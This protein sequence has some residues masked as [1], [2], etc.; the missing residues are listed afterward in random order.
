MAESTRMPIGGR[1]LLTLFLSVFFGFGVVFIVIITRGLVDVAR[2]RDWNETPC[3]I[4]ASE[5]G[6]REEAEGD[7]PAYAFR[8]AYRYTHDGQTHTSKAWRL[9][10]KG[11]DQFRDAQRLVEHY[12]VGAETTCYVNPSEPSAAVLEHG[13]LWL[14]L[15]LLLPLVF[16]CVGAGGIYL[17]WRPSK[18]EENKE[19]EKEKAISSKPGRATGARVGSIV[20][21]AFFL[22]GAAFLVFWF[23]PAAL[24]VLDAEGWDET[25]CTVL[26]SRV[27]AH[28]G[29]DS[30]TYSVDILYAYTVDGKEYK[31]SGYNFLGGSSSRHRAKAEIVKRHKPG[32][33]TV[34]FVNPDDPWDAVLVRGFTAGFLFGLIP[35][36]FAAI[37]GIG[38]AFT[39]RRSRRQ[40]AEPPQ[41]KWVPKQLLQAAAAGEPLP[42]GPVVLKPEASPRAKFVALV[43]FMLIWNSIISVFLWDVVSGWRKGSPDWFETFFI[44]PF[45]LVGLGLIAGVVYC[46]LGLFSPRPQLTVSAPVAPLGGSLELEWVTLGR[47]GSVRKLTI[48]L[49]GREEAKYTRGTDTVTDEHVFARVPVVE[50]EDRDTILAGQASLVVP[51]DTMHSFEAAHNKI[52][53]SIHVHADVRRWP[54]SKEDYPIVVLPV[55]AAEEETT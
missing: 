10:D 11:F 48:A 9:E 4:I 17:L 6:L 46:F 30:T 21:G 2:T 13:S 29:D 24:R 54:D 42:A 52:I 51:R 55:L 19:E 31:S 39:S 15:G 38:F 53:W 50:V 47:I 14:S 12:P 28:T 27:R 3:T 16:V 37:G 41:A 32:T 43:V 5:A 36:V 49:K 1:V 7:E 23:V 40:R 22:A 34:C 25:P 44:I 45:L 35:L 26:F 18:A 8:V 20:F 33:K